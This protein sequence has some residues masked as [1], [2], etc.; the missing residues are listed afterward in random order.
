MK[1]ASKDE[2]HF[3]KYWQLHKTEM[4]NVCNNI[5]NNKILRNKM[6]V[7]DIKHIYVKEN[8]NN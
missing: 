8:L 1:P 3:F 4:N 2:L 7:T 6:T 5:S